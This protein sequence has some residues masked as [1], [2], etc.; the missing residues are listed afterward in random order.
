MYVLQKY[1]KIWLNKFEL[2][3]DLHKIQQ[4]KYNIIV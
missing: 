2:L 1:K 4:Y 3:A